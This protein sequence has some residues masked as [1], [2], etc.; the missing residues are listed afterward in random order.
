MQEFP[1]KYPTEHAFIKASNVA[2]LP[3]I[4]ELSYYSEVRVV[5]QDV[6]QIMD[7]MTPK[8]IRDSA[9][10]SPL[11]ISDVEYPTFDA[12]LAS[13]DRI[14]NLQLVP[15]RS[16]DVQVEYEQ[17]QR[18]TFLHVIEESYFR[19]RSTITLVREIYRSDLPQNIGQYVVWVRDD[20]IP[21]S[22]IA[23]FIARIMHLAD[24][25]PDD[26]ILFERSRVTETPFVRAGIPEHR[27]IHLWM[28][29]A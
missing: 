9:S 7:L 14:R 2:P 25:T 19:D 15:V 16:S 6:Q 26:L 18:E 5:P 24:A 28:R 21:D 20:T 17:I 27:H 23:E 11:M 8:E 29:E 13:R 12:L 3:Y 1:V 4:M 22:E 10:H